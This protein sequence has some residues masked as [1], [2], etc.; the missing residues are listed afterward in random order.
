MHCRIIH[1]LSSL[2]G[3]PDIRGGRRCD[4]DREHKAGGCVQRPAVHQRRKCGEGHALPYRG[5][6]PGRHW[7]AAHDAGGQLRTGRFSQGNCLIVNYMLLVFCPAV[8][9][10]TLSLYLAAHKEGKTQPADGEGLWH[11]TKRLAIVSLQFTLIHTSMSHNVVTPD[12]G[13]RLW[14]RKCM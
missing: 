5:H 4:F 8:L 12:R 13:W 11:F 3:Q 1:A 2:L 6:G 7:E 10:T 9:H 14:R